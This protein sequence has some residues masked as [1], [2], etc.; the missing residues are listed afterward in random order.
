MA[1]NSGNC[2]Q[3]PVAF[4]IF[5]LLGMC[6]YIVA[7]DDS[8]ITRENMSGVNDAA[9]SSTSQTK[10][11]QTVQENQDGVVREWKG[12]AV[13]QISASSAGGE[14]LW[15]DVFQGTSLSESGSQSSAPPS[16]PFLDTN[17]NAFGPDGAQ[18]V[19][20]DRLDDQEQ[21]ADITS[22][23]ELLPQQLNDWFETDLN[24]APYN[25]DQTKLIDRSSECQGMNTVGQSHKNA[26]YDLRG[27]VVIPKISIGPW[28]NSSY[29]QKT[30]FKTLCSDP[31][32]SNANT[33]PGAPFVQAQ[34]SN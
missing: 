16:A 13:T 5:I 19:Y 4:L 12:E 21:N 31:S 6:F 3:T 8:C 10:A 30:Q 27:D 15:S 23:Q 9:Q 18:Q 11:D 7:T 1:N 29:D 2:F 24:Q 22:A 28:N 26:N 17:P 33:T 14:T 25:V 32:S 34:I 20:M